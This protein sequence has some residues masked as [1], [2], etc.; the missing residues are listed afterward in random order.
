MPPMIADISPEIGGAPDAA[1]TPRPS[2]RATKDTLM[3]A[4]KSD[5]QCEVIPFQPV[6]GVLVI[7]IQ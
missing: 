1:A 7:F 4:R 2:G 3:A 6:L 5:R